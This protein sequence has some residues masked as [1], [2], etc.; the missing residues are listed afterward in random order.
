MY[1]HNVSLNGSLSSTLLI[2]KYK[3]NGGHITK[4]KLSKSENSKHIVI[5]MS[6][7]EKEKHEK[8]SILHLNQEFKQRTPPH[9]GMN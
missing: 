9:L 1:C 3:N 2:A 7:P 6:I 8:L 4:F 5:L